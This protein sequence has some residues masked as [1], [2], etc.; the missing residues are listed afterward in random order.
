ML[1]PA[2]ISIPLRQFS[3]QAHTEFFLIFLF[4][5][6]KQTIQ[7]KYLSVFIVVI[8]LQQGELIAS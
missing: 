5:I 8:S 3:E 7:K 4:I 6:G 1:Q 2:V